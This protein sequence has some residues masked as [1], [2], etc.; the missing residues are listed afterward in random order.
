ME[1]HD[2]EPAVG[3]YELNAQI[4]Q[5]A[6]FIVPGFVTVPAY[7]GAQMV[8]EETDVLPVEEPVVKIPTGQVVHEVDP[9]EPAGHVCASAC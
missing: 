8:Q 2:E 5:P 7:P 4:E 1:V 9:Y 3:A 6:A